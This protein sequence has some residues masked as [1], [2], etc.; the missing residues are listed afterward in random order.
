[1]E[2]RQN[3][4]EP[5][6]A[7]LWESFQQPLGTQLLLCSQTRPEVQCQEFL[8]SLI[9]LRYQPLS[10]GLWAW[11]PP[12]LPLRWCLSDGQL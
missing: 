5:G 11:A 3:C 6:T 8:P 12:S 4:P 9:L 7:L 1:M 10:W 2:D